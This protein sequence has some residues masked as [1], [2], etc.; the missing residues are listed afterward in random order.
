MQAVLQLI[1]MLARRILVNRG[2]IPK[3]MR[4]TAL[5]EMDPERNFRGVVRVSEQVIYHGP[6][7]GNAN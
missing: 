4:T 3:S 5:E 6:P 7:S 2:W 1:E